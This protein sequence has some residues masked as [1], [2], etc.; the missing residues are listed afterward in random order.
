MLK[1]DFDLYVN[2]DWIL[3]AKIPDGESTTGAMDDVE[4]TL[5]DRQIALMQDDSL[6]G[7]DA[8]LVRKLYAMVSDWDY[9]NAQGVEPAMPIM[10]SIRNIDSLEA[11]TAYLYDRNNLKRYYPL[12]MAVSADLINP[13]IYIT[14]IGTPSLML[15]DSAE[16]KERT[17]AG[18]LYCSLYE[19]LGTYINATLAQFDDF[20]DFYGIQPGDGMYVAPEDRVAV[21]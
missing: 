9:R 14:Q 10:E 17:Q 2:K 7:H 18:D 11:L 4:R 5:K 6:T 20:I 19:Q 8:E 16:Y 12:V 3:Q 13:D 15:Q 21:W 1:D